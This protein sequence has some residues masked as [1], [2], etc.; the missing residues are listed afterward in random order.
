MICSTNNHGLVKRLS[1]HEDAVNIE[2]MYNIMDY[3]K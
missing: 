3:S 1:I 2:N